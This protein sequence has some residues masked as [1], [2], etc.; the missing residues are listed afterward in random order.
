MTYI[1]T[2]DT[3]ITHITGN[4]LS[5]PAHTELDGNQLMPESVLFHLENGTLEE[6]TEVEPT[7]ESTSNI[8]PKV[9][10]SKP[11]ANVPTTQNGGANPP[12]EDRK[13]SK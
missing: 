13:E 9:T 3:T 4:P 1:T 5:I 12:Q 10:T 2:A 7:I 8:K 11:T 6:V